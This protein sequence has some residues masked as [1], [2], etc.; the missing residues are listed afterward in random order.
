MHSFQITDNHPAHHVH[1]VIECVY[2]S[3]AI[4]RFLPPYS[5]DLNPIK[6][7]FTNVKHNLRL[8]DLVQQAVGNLSALI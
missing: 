6:E 8:N 4:I 7:A 2:Q 3:G 5:P 1:Q